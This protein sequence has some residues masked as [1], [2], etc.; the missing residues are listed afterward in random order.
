[1]IQ[2]RSEPRFRTCF[3]SGPAGPATAAI[4]DML[5]ARGVATL[6]ANTIAL[7]ASIR[8]EI[9]RSIAAAD[10]VVV[11]LTDYG[12]Q[13]AIFEL[14]VARGMN[15]PLL[16]VTSSGVLPS[17]LQGIVYR[18]LPSLDRIGEVAVDIDRFLRNAK[19]P[20][21]LSAEPPPAPRTDLGWARDEL[22]A[23]R[24]SAD[25]RRSQN[26]EGLVGRI[27]EAAGADVQATRD[28]QVER[29]VDFV[30]WL[31]DIAYALGGP[32][33]VECKFLLGGAGSVIKNAEGY[34][35]QLRRSLESSDASLALLVF[36]HL[37][38]TAPSTTFATFAT[39]NVIAIAAEQVIDGLEAGT[40]EQEILRRRRRAF[41]VGGGN[42]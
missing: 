5:A 23:L 13:N 14:G 36:D 37:R 21:T 35:D 19:P 17:D 20:P 12:A 9:L 25:P 2:N 29:G 39:P 33:L 42:A 30:V 11:L 28:S 32:I 4:A 7:G 40:F 6:S 41:L 15:K 31:N 3:V 26:F 38:P 34:V 10:F 16:V 27:F 24:H 18:S 22:R 1:M 8:D